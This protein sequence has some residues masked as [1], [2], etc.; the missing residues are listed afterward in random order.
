MVRLF[1]WQLKFS[2]PESCFPI[3]DPNLSENFFFPRPMKRNYSREEGIPTEENVSESSL[4]I[5]P[6][7]P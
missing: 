2:F 4:S 5:R 6:V 1:E 3:N 7:R